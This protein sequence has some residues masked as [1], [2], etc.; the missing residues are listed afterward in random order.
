MMRYRFSWFGGYVYVSPCSVL[1]G[2]QGNYIRDFDTFANIVKGPYKFPRGVFWETNLDDVLT[3]KLF[4][5]EGLNRCVKDYHLAQIV[6][7]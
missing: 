1:F 3:F 6:P 2:T 4:K 7:L 5:K